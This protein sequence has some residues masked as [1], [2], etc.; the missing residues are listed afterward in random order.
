MRV[1]HVGG[2]PELEMEG[3]SG[4]GHLKQADGRVINEENKKGWVI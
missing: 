2:V 1:A 3:L 4:K